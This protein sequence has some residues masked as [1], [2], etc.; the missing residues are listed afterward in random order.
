MIEE[1]LYERLGG[2]DAI[3]AVINGVVAALGGGCAI[4]PFLA[5]PGA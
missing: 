1:S 3:N 5:K 4:G 2:Y